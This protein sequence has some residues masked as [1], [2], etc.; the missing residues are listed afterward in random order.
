LQ[1]IIEGLRAVPVQVDINVVPVQD[2]DD[3]IES[4]SKRPEVAPLDIKP[5]VRQGEQL[6]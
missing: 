5:E 2:E 1:R 3:S 6:E 4:I